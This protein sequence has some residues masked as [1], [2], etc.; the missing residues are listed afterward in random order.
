LARQIFRQAHL[1]KKAVR[2]EKFLARQPI[3]TT[4][5]IV[6]GY[7]LLFR[8]GPENSYVSTQPDFAAASS[9]DSL[10]L[11]GI[12]RFT[13]GRRAFINC[14]REFLIRDYPMLLPRDR[15]V[16]EILE[17][18]RIDEQVIAACRRL[19]E[20]GYLIA[21]DD[22]VDTPEWR[23]LIPFADFLKVDLLITSPAEQNRLAQ[24]YRRTGIA[25]LAERVETYQDFQ[26]TLDWGY[27][28]FQGFF[29]A[30]PQMLT[31]HDIPAYKLQYLRVLQAA[32]QP[33]MNTHLVAE[34]IKEES[35]LSY[36]LLRYLNSPAFPILTE[37][38]SIPHALSLLGEHGIRRWVS[39]VAIACLGEG[40]PVELVMLP[41]IRAR[42]LE[43]LALPV[44]MES[45]ANDLFLLGLLSVVDAILDMTMSNVLREIPVHADIR[46]AL[47][48]T[49]NRL[50]EMLEIVLLYER[51]D[52][53]GVHVA[54][55]R[56]GLTGDAVTDLFVQS[57]DW[58]RGVLNGQPAA[59]PAPSR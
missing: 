32:N 6:Y 42:F 23:V 26:R 41:L 43:L 18:V 10:L 50:R 58:A 14:T 33:Q 13:D 56:L 39:L 55:A 28:Y 37:I 24:A 17:T 51:G 31:R 53:E 8:S 9:T 49:H 46:G 47:L 11:F 15:I 59:D 1:G 54:A 22:F 7:E 5:R 3:F 16:V 57:V 35:S 45:S 4:N 27:T 52:W 36:R 34:R 19:K 25:L 29:F 21:L 30:R 12:E 2:L 40:K 44:R 20:S 48:G 38:R